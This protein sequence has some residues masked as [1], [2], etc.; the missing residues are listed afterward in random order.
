MLSK[1]IQ[2]AIE[3]NA[4]RI[5]M[6]PLNKGPLFNREEIREGLTSPCRWAEP[7]IVRLYGTA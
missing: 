3:R 5:W 2:N 6:S 1:N 4:E 7:C